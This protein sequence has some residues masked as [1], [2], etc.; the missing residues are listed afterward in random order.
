MS[1]INGVVLEREK[2][3]LKDAFWGGTQLTDMKTRY[4]WFMVNQPANEFY[5]WFLLKFDA[6]P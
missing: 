6:L 5:T 2:I 1:Y 3:A 4:N